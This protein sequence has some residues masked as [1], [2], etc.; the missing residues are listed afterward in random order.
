M[1]CARSYFEQLPAATRQ[2]YGQGIEVLSEAKVPFLIGGA[3]ALEAYAGINRYTKDL[4]FFVRAEDCQR[5]LGIFAGRGFHT[6]LRFPHWL[7]KVFSP[8]GDFIDVIF[9]SGNGI[10]RVDNDWFIHAVEHRVLG[11]SVLLSP[12][13]EMI[14]S[15]AFVMERERYDGADIAHLLR[16]RAAQLDWPRLRGRFGPDWRLLLT[17]L[18][19]FGFIYPGERSVIPAAVLNELLDRLRDEIAAGAPVAEPI[20]QG[21]ILSR[22]QFLVDV[23]CWGYRDARSR[24]ARAR[25][26]SPSAR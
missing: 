1:Q 15:K 19:L 13:E 14:W 21:T 7:G 20:C 5:I 17:Y 10:A 16:A 12:V 11:R 24:S 23:D 8:E 26:S 9:G 25:L 18:V 6:E 2:F 3:C 22:E 4:D